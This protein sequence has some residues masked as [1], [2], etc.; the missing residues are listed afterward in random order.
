M[1]NVHEG[2]LQRQR[3]RLQ[4]QEMIRGEDTGG[5]LADLID[6]ELQTLIPARHMQ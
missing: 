4:N 5:C 6:I 3:A 1:I 2:I